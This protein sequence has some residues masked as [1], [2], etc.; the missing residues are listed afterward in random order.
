MSNK[1][2]ISLAILWVLLPV[3]CGYAQ[4]CAMLPFDT[5][6]SWM[7]IGGR[8]IPSGNDGNVNFKV[9]VVCIEFP[10]DTEDPGDGADSSTH[11]WR[12]CMAPRYLRPA[13]RSEILDMTPNEPDTIKGNK[14]NLGP[15][16]AR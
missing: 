9:L 16:I 8:D 3:L 14:Y 10:G 15:T 1:R 7:R 12:Y 4:E 6:W 2:V 13:G 11:P 5:S